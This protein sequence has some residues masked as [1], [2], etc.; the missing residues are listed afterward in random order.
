MLSTK[1]SEAVAPRGHLSAF[2]PENRG[3]TCSLLSS[4]IGMVI[5]ALTMTKRN[6]ARSLDAFSLTRPSQVQNARRSAT[7]ALDR[8]LSRFKLYLHRSTMLIATRFPVVEY[9]KR[10]VRLPLLTPKPTMCDEVASPGEAEGASQK[11]SSQITPLLAGPLQLTTASQPP[12]KKAQRRTAEEQ[13][14]D[15]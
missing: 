9:N 2:R 3:S 6:E 11:S 14:Q 1:F 10:K 4:I 8:L 13:T 5:W 7:G 12:L 15:Q